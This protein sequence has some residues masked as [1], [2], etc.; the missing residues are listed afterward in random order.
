MGFMD[1]AKEMAGDNSDKIKDAA[2]GQVDQ[3][4]DGGKAD[5]VKEGVD[6][7]IDKALGG[8]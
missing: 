5:K 2:H 6:K 1:K 3:R 8:E 7:G 4:V